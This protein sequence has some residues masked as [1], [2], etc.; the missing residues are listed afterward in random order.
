MHL[1]GLALGVRRLAEAE[2]AAHGMPLERVHFHEVGATDSIVDIMAAAVGGGLGAGA[3]MAGPR[4]GAS[5][6]RC[7]ETEDR[8]G[9]GI[10]L[11][12]AIRK[13]R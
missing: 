4:R 8:R 13:I 7:Q 9:G 10:A 5:V 1:E 2:A 12:E 11:G 6:E 3:S